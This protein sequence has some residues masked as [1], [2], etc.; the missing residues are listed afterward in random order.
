METKTKRTKEHAK[1]KMHE[2]ARH[3]GTFPSK[4]IKKWREKKTKHTTQKCR[5]KYNSKN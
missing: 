2:I 5:K 3:K 1:W 4:D